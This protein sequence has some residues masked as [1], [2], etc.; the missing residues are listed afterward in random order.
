MSEVLVTFFLFRH[1]VQCGFEGQAGWASRTFCYRWHLEAGRSLRNNP[2]I[3]QQGWFTGAPP[4]GGMESDQRGS[5][6]ASGCSLQVRD[7]T[8][9]TAG[10]KWTFKGCVRH[11]KTSTLKSWASKLDCGQ[12][13]CSWQNEMYPARKITLCRILD[14]YDYHI[15]RKMS[16]NI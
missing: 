4:G 9:S 14:I 3:S 12:P 13:E 8:C 16:L 1:Q 2:G 5:C 15:T 10:G 11:P 6:P 7:S